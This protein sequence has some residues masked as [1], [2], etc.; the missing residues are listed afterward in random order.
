M[1]FLSGTPAIGGTMGS[2]RVVGS[3]IRCGWCSCSGTG[4][5]WW[6]VVGVVVSSSLVRVKDKVGGQVESREE[7]FF[8]SQ[9]SHL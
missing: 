5:P 4:G 9:P 1:T 2:V 6:T 3:L 7:G 8:S